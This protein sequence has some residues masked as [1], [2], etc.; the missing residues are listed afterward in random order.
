MKTRTSFSVLAVAVL[1]AVAALTLAA[2]GDGGG[3]PYGG[4]GGGAAA[5]TSSPP[6]A[7]GATT[8]EI[9]IKNFSFTP[10]ETTVPAGTTVTWTNED[11]TV[12]DVTS[13][14][15]PGI[16]AAVTSTFASGTLAEGDTFEFTFE[17]PGTYHYECTIHATMQTMHAVVIVE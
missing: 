8:S 11:T 10:A 7:D 3:S 6:A 13:T 2:C 1:L 15:G 4:G 14:D 17:D 9:S 5:G 16:D 12:H